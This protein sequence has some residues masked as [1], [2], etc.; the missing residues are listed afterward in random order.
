MRQALVLSCYLGLLAPALASP[1]AWDLPEGM[2]WQRPDQLYS[3]ATKPGSVGYFIGC[4]FG[5][6]GLQTK[7]G[8]AFFRICQGVRETYPFLVT[9]F[10]RET[11]TVRYQTGLDW[12]YPL[13]EGSIDPSLHYDEI[14][15]LAGSCWRLG[16]TL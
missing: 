2:R 4:Y 12:T 9:D 10:E 6:V 15:E 16:T 1:P 3:C 5:P 8:V 13:A 7:T 14:N 11:V